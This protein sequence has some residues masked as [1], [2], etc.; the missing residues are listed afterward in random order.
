MLAE[1]IRVKINNREFDIDGGGLTPLELSARANYV[2]EQIEAV[3]DKT[4]T[5]DTSKLA[6]L[7][8]LNI[9]DELFR[10]K[11]SKNSTNGNN[12]KKLDE[13]IIQLDSAIND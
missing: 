10:V 3:A 5:V 1:K 8:A 12:D 13:L 6:V 4:N 2:N 9:A 7:A 11:E